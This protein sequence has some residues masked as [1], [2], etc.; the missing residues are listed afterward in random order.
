M[1]R[2]SSMNGMKQGKYSYVEREAM[3]SFLTTLSAVLTS[4]IFI[5][6]MLFL[7]YGY[8]SKFFSFYKLKKSD[9]I[10]AVGYMV[11]TAIIAIITYAITNN[12]LKKKYNVHSYQIGV[13]DFMK[14]Y[15]IYVISSASSL[16][17]LF[18]TNQKQSNIATFWAK[19]LYGP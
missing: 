14:F 18:V 11:V 5:P 1:N 16:S 13:K 7:H 8:S 2:S 10:I 4:F 12:F 17:L 19:D 3:Y 15:H 9:V 6:L